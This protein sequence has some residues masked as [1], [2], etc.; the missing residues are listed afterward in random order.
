MWR[1]V[2]LQCFVRTERPVVG[3][4]ASFL[5][6]QTFCRE[7]PFCH[8]LPPLRYMYGERSA[9][10]LTGTTAPWSVDAD[11]VRDQHVRAYA[12]RRK[13]TI[14]SFEQTMKRP[15][16]KIGHIEPLNAILPSRYLQPRL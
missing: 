14:S 11:I 13:I 1:A 15:M 2:C 7:R 6:S 3:P 5:G 10:F 4:L 16:L 8:M 9:H 12:V